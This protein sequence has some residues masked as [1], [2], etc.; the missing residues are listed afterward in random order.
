VNWVDI[1]LLL[2]VVVSG[3]HGLRLGA[4]M[5]VLSF[6]G[7]WLGL[8]IG[9]VI[10]PPLAGLVHS[11]GMKTLIAALVVFGMAGIL[12][13]VGRYLGAHSSLALRRLKLGPVDSAAGVAVAVFATL[14]AAWLVASIV[15][16]SRFTSLNSAITKSRIVRAMDDVMP[17]PPE[18]FSRIESFLE[19][20]G[21]PIVFAG[22]PPQLS[23]PVAPPSNSAIA[24]A[25]ADAE[26]STVQI[27]GAGCGVIQE[28]SGFVVA[29]GLVVTNAHVVAGIARPLVIDQSGHHPATAV[30]YDPEL[31][32]AVLR[33]PGLHDPVLNVYGGLVGRGT[34]G[35]VLGFPEGG[36]FTPVPAGVADSFSATGLDIYSNATVTR[37]IY[38]LDAQV[39]PGNSGGPLIASGDSS[40]GIPDGTVIGVVFARSTTSSGV[41]YALAMPAVDKDIATARSSTAPVSTGACAAG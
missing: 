10:T 12:G 39:L 4:A 16:N 2:L 8:F 38:E 30:L 32:I 41:G 5:Q 11:T 15:T 26:P 35:A 21:F 6:G 27:A 9:A 17:Q 7:F 14:V 3:I 23:P 19:S 13:G 29:P 28:G 36:P 24:A 40:A 20:E 1:V 34:S 31:D 25:V 18:I 22:L 33:V 37:E